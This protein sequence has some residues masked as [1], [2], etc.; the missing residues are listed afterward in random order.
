MTKLRQIKEV[1]SGR[2][3]LGNFYEEIIRGPSESESH[4]TV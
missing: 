1:M 3:P 2:N 4:I